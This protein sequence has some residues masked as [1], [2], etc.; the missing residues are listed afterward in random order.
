MLCVYFTIITIW[1]PA[2]AV[3]KFE[4]WRVG[5][6]YCHITPRPAK[7]L[8]GRIKGMF[9]ALLCTKGL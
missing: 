9:G 3:T 1:R 4:I 6:D 8:I 7:L 5:G 2:V